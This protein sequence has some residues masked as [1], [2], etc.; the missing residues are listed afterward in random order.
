M[1]DWTKDSAPKKARVTALMQEL[2]KA[3][4]SPACGPEAYREKAEE[5]ASM[6]QHPHAGEVSPRPE[7]PVGPN[8]QPIEE[9]WIEDNLGNPG[10]A[11]NE[12]DDHRETPY[13]TRKEEAEHLRSD[14]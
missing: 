5:L 9:A 1:N 12:L 14:D 10:G 7:W 4:Q 6:E 8:G 3:D 11:M 2:W 13:A